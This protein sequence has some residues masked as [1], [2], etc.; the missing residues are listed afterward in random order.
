MKTSSFSHF[1]LL[2][3][4]SS[5]AAVAQQT[6]KP[7]HWKLAPKPP[8]GWNS[9]DAF[10]D[11]VTEAE[12]LANAHYMK[13]H[14][15]SHGWNHV[16]IDFRWY[17]S[18]ATYDDTKLTKERMG[19]VLAADKFGR[20]LPAV[21]RF[22]SA[23]NGRGFKPLADRIH[24][25]GMKFGFHMMR[26]IPRQAVA[27]RTP[28]EGS[29]F[30]AADAANSNSKCGW[31]PDMFGVADNAA[32]QAW[33]DSC[34]RL[35]ASW[36]LDFVKVDDL[37]VPYSTHEIGMLRRAID[38]CARPIVL[39]TSPG[40]TPVEKADHV[41]A[42][43]NMWRISGDFWDEWKKL[44]HQF[45][46]LAQWQ[47]VGG[48]GH[49]PDADMIPFG[50][51]G[52]RNWT[53]NTPSPC[54]R[55]TRFTPDEQRALMSLWALAPS[56]LMLGMNLPDLDSATLELITNDEVIAINQDPDGKPARLLGKSGPG[57]EVWLR[58]L[59]GGAW[60]AGFF[61]RGDSEAKV[62]L[63]WADAGLSGKLAA[64]DVWQ[65]RALGIFSGDLSQTVAAHGAVL[66]KLQPA[67]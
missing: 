46:L 36:G 32:G 6:S 17:D 63:H 50:H 57:G 64:R 66:I 37:S 19:A 49:W 31:C 23:A 28:I 16:V 51:I 56:P 7:A 26:G 48:P 42:N 47:G 45:D 5:S 27:A 62:N 20:L 4:L 22:P 14:L 21:N 34:A 53:P 65:K 3:A 25:M 11:S 24:A 59:R 12:T 41:K 35:W 52:I 1:L 38:K 33:Y 44:N 29:A 55:W 60:V 9:Y 61:N 15:L 8:M 2:I 43:A 18:V 39:S 67:K 54:E 40:P 30:T 13:E 58:E 10:G